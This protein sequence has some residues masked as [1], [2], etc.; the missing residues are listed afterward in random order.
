VS[1]PQ[2]PD[3]C[4]CGQPWARLVDEVSSTCVG[5]WSPEG[6]DHDDNCVTR[7]LLCAGGCRRRLGIRRRCNDHAGEWD[8]GPEAPACDWRGKEECCGD[9]AYVDEWPAIG[10]TP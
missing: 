1:K 3:K 4:E 2:L 5:Y 7:P 10:A 9:Y 6:H 8:I